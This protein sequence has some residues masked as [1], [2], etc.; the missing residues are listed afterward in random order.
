MPKKK[1]I[2]PAPNSEQKLNDALVHKRIRTF[3]YSDCPQV[4]KRIYDLHLLRELQIHDCQSPL[5]QGIAQLG[6]L[7]KISL[8]NLPMPQVPEDFSQLAQLQYIDISHCQ[9]Q[10]LPSQPLACLPQLRELSLPNNQIEE[11]PSYLSEGKELQR[12]DLSNNPLKE[13]PQVLL[14]LPKLESIGT[15]GLRIFH[16]QF[17]PEQNHKRFLQQL[18]S[19][20]VPENIR[21]DL[22]LLLS[23]DTQIAANVSLQALLFGLK[24]PNGLVSRCALQILQNRLDAAY[25]QRPL[26]AGA[27]LYALGKLTQPAE[28]LRE[29]LQSLGL[30][31][32][33]TLSEDCT[34][35]L[36]GTK[37]INSAQLYALHCAPQQLILSA[38][39]TQFLQSQDQ[40]Y[41]APATEDNNSEEYAQKIRSLLRHEDLENVSLALQMMQ[42]GGVPKGAILELFIIARFRQNGYFWGEGYP[43]DLRKQAID[44]LRQFA[45]QALY[46]ESRLPSILN[47]GSHLEAGIWRV[48]LQ[49]GYFHWRDLYEYDQAKS[50]IKADT[51]FWVTVL[52]EKDAVEYLQQYTAQENYEIDIE[53]W[54]KRA[55]RSYL[56]LP[57]IKRISLS[58]SA[59]EEVL[60]MQ[61]L[62]H[63]SFRSPESCDQNFIARLGQLPNLRS[64]YF[65]HYPQAHIPLALFDAPALR[66]LSVRFWQ[67]AP[68]KLD[69]LPAHFKFSLLSKKQV[70]IERIEVL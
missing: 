53:R 47:K 5:P 8:R 1:V 14:H 56:K 23:D 16:K 27:K 67:K 37:S 34:H 50:N 45:P 6:Q 13:F 30:T 64:I 65:S 24:F 48:F 21:Y 62:S 41:L 58:S 69:Y 2:K 22:Y 36:I 46:L 4:D 3:S 60:Q 18:H 61:Q 39:L 70:L 38:H 28:E 11:V 54:S 15:K 63:L 35:I 57:F 19:E 9:L 31:L 52:P 10:K 25:P 40:F 43:S 20:N 44:L 49:K 32:L 59:Y 55:R 68:K 42:T 29:Q 7:Q 12:L 26:R 33:P 17:A 66:T 51:D